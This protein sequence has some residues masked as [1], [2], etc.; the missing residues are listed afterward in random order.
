[1][2][3]RK[4]PI[5]KP[6]IALVAAILA[7]AGGAVLFLSDSGSVVAGAVAKQAEGARAST[8]VEAPDTAPSEGGVVVN[9]GQKDGSGLLDRSVY[10][11]NS[12]LGEQ[13]PDLRRHAEG[14]NSYATCVLAV[15]LDRC[16]QRMM[17]Y[18]ENPWSD[19][20]SGDTIENGDDAQVGKISAE[21][22]KHKQTALMCD[23]VTQTDM[24]ERDRWM[25]RS[26]KAG[27]PR[28][29]ALYALNPMFGGSMRLEDMDRM[30]DYTKNAESMLNRAASAGVPEAIAGVY[31]A[32]SYG[33]IGTTVGEVAVQKNPAKAAG[34]A[35]AMLEFAAEAEKKEIQRGIDDLVAKMDSVERSRIASMRNSYIKAYRT[36]FRGEKTGAAA[37]IESPDSICSSHARDQVHFD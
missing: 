9:I 34:A 8:G 15:A 14:G 31:R 35:M 10:D 30:A 7:V 37:E 24:L 1:M 26:A 12:P 23:D 29:M 6:S 13:L 5:R 32:Y 16:V 18:A 33:A 36:Q 19:V 3:D 25:Q 11:R 17:G 21:L 2:S 27:N 22:E 4:D 20:S 28:S